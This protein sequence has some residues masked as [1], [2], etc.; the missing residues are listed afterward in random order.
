MPAAAPH[1][2]EHQALDE[3]HAHQPCARCAQRGA[4]AICSRRLRPRASSRF[5]TLAQATNRTQTAASNRSSRTV[6]VR[7]AHAGNAGAARRQPHRLPLQ[8]RLFR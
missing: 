3:R 4:S 8:D 1:H 5:A 6:L 2:R 7:Q